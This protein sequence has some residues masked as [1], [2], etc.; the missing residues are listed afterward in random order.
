M[1]TTV[2]G[3]ES[4]LL[5]PAEPG[6]LSVIWRRFRKHKLALM[7]LVILVVMALLCIGAPLVSPHTPEELD[8]IN[9]FGP[10]SFDFSNPHW[11]GTD[12]FGRDIFTRLLY[13]GRISLTVGILAT[14]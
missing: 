11:L 8:L 4:E 9:A 3:L 14:L 6:Q 13:A 2:Q 10:P 5:A 12:D 1:A 7:G